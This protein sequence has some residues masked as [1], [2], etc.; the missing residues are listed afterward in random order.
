MA[1]FEQGLVREVEVKH[2]EVKKLLDRHRKLKREVA[3]LT[4]YSAYSTA[5]ELRQK[6][7]K[8]EKMRTKELL[9]S[10]LRTIRS[11]MV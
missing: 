1:Y 7:L 5:A 3:A 8:R 6:A 4:P 2:P 10:L 9:V 11:E